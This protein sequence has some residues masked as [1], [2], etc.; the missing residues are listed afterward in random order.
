MTKDKKTQRKRLAKPSI[1]WSIP[2]QEK[3]FFVFA[4]GIILLII[5]FY[6]MTI[7]PWDSAFALIISPLIL[8]IAYFIIFPLGILLDKD[9]KHS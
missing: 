7:Q 8:L 5:G 3:N 4:I 1:K 9:N 2:V 6:L